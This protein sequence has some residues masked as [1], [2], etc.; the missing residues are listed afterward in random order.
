MT[1]FE[2]FVYYF[3]WLV[4]YGSVVGLAALGV[5]CYFK[6][7]D[8][9]V[10]AFCRRH[11]F[12]TIPLFLVTTAYGGVKFFRYLKIP[13]TDPDVQNIVDHGSYITNDCAYIS[14]NTVGLPPDAPILVAYAPPEATNESQ[15]VTVA[16]LTLT[17][18][19]VQ[20]P[21]K[22]GADV[23]A[24]FAW[25][26]SLGDRADEY[27]WYLYTT[28]TPAPSVHTNGVL[29]CYGIKVGDIGGVLK[30]TVL[31]EN[32]RILSPDEILGDFEDS[33]DAILDAETYEGEERKPYELEEYF[34]INR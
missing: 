26:T 3:N 18:W 23:T 20:F 2:T 34:D 7:I 27:Q 12:I 31:I 32:G 9:V 22:D 15:V 1:M 11:P 19:R 8:H 14:F 5:A 33:K 28:W 6:G 4:I 16:D 10:R 25:N 29:N 17:Q 30:R 24:R 21:G 13:R